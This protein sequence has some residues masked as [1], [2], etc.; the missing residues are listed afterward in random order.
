M[1]RH[2]WGCLQP[3]GKNW[4]FRYPV[5]R[6]SD[7]K[8]VEHTKVVGLVKQLT[9]S[10]AWDEVER[11]GLAKSLNKPTTGKLR[12][13]DVAEHYKAFALG[14]KGLA[15]PMS[16]GTVRNLRHIVDDYLNPRWGDRI[17][18]E[19]KPLEIEQWLVSLHED[20][21]LAWPTIDKIH[22]TMSQVYQHA[23]RYG[24]VPREMDC[25][26]F[27]LVR[28]QCSS[29]YEARTVTTQQT[30][31]ILSFL[32]L[33]EA[34]LTLL[35]AATGLRISE[36]L[37]L[38]WSDLDYSKS[39]IHVR[40]TWLNGIIGPPKTKASRAAV[41]MHP[42]LAAYMLTWHKETVYGMPD[43]WVFASRKLKGTQPRTG[44]MLSEDYLRPAAVKAGVIGRDE[45]VRFGFHNLRHSLATF[46]VSSA[47]DPKTVQ[48]ML[49]HANVATTLGLY[50][51]AVDEKKLE[52]QGGYLSSLLKGATWRAA[53]PRRK[54]SI[55]ASWV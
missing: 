8:R 5:V 54:R 30:F 17:A 29:E 48:A 26:P 11:L 35:I 2:K 6:P 9:E 4:V 39:C 43:D 15:D 37:G 34:T 55:S 25:N 22:R 28:C 44:N 3:K 21:K 51:H 41:P 32:E 12:F 31:A 45:K 38:R 10:E 13:N 19:I 53:S 14:T 27:H 49:R 40:R 33:L 47:S 23:Q 46:L 36:A 18:Q 7:G 50:A 52:A 20:R 1:T 16:P 24:L 42:V